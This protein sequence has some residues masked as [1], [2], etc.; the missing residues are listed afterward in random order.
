[1][2]TGML[3][4]PPQLTG[5]SKKKYVVRFMNEKHKN[6]CSEVEQVPSTPAYDATQ[7]WAILS[8]VDLLK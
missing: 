7:S 8:S 5:S 4:I 3:T 6:D 1:M 2:M